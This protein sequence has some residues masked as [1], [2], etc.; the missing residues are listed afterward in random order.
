[1]KIKILKPNEYNPTKEDIIRICN[2]AFKEQE[3]E[4]TKEILYLKE[5]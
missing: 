2:E 1:M 3:E 4:I 5:H